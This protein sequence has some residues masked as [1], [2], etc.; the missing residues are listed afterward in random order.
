MQA[1]RVRPLDNP[2]LTARAIMG[3]LM[4]HILLQ[5]V[6]GG[7]HVTTID[8]EVWIHE[9]IDIALNGIRA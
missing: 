7:K 8:E 3:L 4:T 5:E 9:I 2:M 1:G 6:L